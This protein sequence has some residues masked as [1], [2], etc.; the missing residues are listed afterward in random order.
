MARTT[1]LLPRK[2]DT[3]CHPG[4]DQNSRELGG[5]ADE[6]RQIPRGFDETQALQ[7]LLDFLDIIWFLFLFWDGQGNQM[8]DD[9]RRL[10]RTDV[11]EDHRTRLCLQNKL[12]LDLI[13]PLG[14]AFFTDAGKLRFRD[15]LHGDRVN[16]LRDGS[17]DALGFIFLY[18]AKELQLSAIVLGLT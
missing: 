13:D 15:R 10:S 8:V 1:E 2:V 5:V 3:R 16:W 7:H 14:L 17:F 9:L 12:Q 11:R 4:M 18:P 6:L